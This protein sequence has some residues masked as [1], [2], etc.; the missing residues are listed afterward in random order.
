MRPRTCRTPAL[1]ALASAGP[2]GCNVVVVGVAAVG[3]ALELRAPSLAARI[4]WPAPPGQLQP[5][6]LFPVIGRA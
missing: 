6:P 4:P 1:Q 3:S 5:L 2:S